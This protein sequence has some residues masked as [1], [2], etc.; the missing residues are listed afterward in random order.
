[1]IRRPPRSTLFPYTTLFRSPHTQGRRGTAPR[2]PLPP[3]GAAPALPSGRW[4]CGAGPRPHLHL[5]APLPSPA[6]LRYHLAPRS[7][8]PPARL[9]AAQGPSPPR[10][11]LRRLPQSLAA[12]I[13][14]LRRHHHL[15]FFNDTATTEIYTL[16]LHDALPISSHSRTARHSSPWSSSAARRSS[17]ASV[18]QMGLRCWSAAASPSTS[19]TAISS[20][21]PIPSSPAEP[22]PSSSPSSSSRPVSSP[23]ASSTP[24]A[25]S[26]CGHSPAA[27]SSSPFFF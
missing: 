3:P 6:H 15:F 20:S 5:P 18:R 12:G 9:R 2:G 23:K 8:L 25:I 22:A 10:R 1:M 27:S 26:R 16:S 24:P 7:R 14:Q 17:C 11:P 13:P 21:S 4:A 19:S